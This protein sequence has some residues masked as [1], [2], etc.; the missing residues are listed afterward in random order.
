MLD[1]E[2]AA[3][4]TTGELNSAVALATYGYPYR[5][6]RRR[7]EATGA[8]IS[9]L[10]HFHPEPL[11]YTKATPDEPMPVLRAQT[12]LRHLRDGTLIQQD[13]CHP[14]L[15]VLHAIHIFECIR[16]FMERAKSYRI[17]HVVG[18][19]GRHS[20]VPGHEPA[21]D[22]KC[23]AVQTESLE[24]ATALVRLGV[25]LLACEGAAPHRRLTLAA[26]G[27]TPP[28]PGT[29]HHTI[30]SDDGSIDSKKLTLAIS[31]GTLAA[32]DPAHPALWCILAL[33][34]RRDM[35]RELDDETV[36]LLLHNPRSHAWARH[37]RSVLML[38][39]HVT[40]R[41]IDRARKFL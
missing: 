17:A 14:L 6:E 8:I 19:Q 35:K 26:E 16:T 37:K 15:D 9:C 11:L 18:G 4:A 38:H 32:R 40:G 10:W 28:E 29:H 33:R 20:L 21:T 39:K 23:P 36:P 31:D 5:L 12:A 25:P 22:N 41:D 3:V 1:Q 24:L 34:N 30:A 7:A 2:G 27:Y 13:P